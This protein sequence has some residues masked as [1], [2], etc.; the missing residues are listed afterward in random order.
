MEV[1]LLSHGIMFQSLSVPITGM[2][3]AFSIAPYPHFHGLSLRSA[4]QYSGEITG[5]PRSARLTVWVRFRL[6]AG[7]YVSMYPHYTRG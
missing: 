3:F 6:F 1:C 5:L 2:A 7:S 4:F